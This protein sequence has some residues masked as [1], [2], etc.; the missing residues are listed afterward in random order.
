MSGTMCLLFGLVEGAAVLISFL[1]ATD[2]EFFWVPLGFML[3]NVCSYGVGVLR[4]SVRTI[5]L[6]ISQ[7]VAPSLLKI[8]TVGAFTWGYALLFRTTVDQTMLSVGLTLVG[9]ASLWGRWLQQL[10]DPSD[11][12]SGK[13]SWPLVSCRCPTILSMVRVCCVPMNA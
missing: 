12:W 1:P 9:L 4:A 8:L 5:G 6:Q 10:T 2:G 13:G 3:A 7:D 11:R